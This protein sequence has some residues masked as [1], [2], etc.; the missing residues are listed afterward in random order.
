[1]SEKSILPVVT[2]FPSARVIRD[3]G[4][5]CEALAVTGRLHAWL[6][7]GLNPRSCKTAQIEQLRR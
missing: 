1:M 4:M 2:V 5:L 3:N 7:S 6:T